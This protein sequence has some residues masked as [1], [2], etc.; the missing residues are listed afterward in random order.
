MNPTKESISLVG[1]GNVGYHLLEAFMQKGVPLS[2]VVSSGPAPSHYTGTVVRAVQELPESQL[3]ILC[4]PDD[5]IA[6]LVTEL[7]GRPLAYTSGSVRLDQLPEGNLGV[8]YPLQTFSKSR[9]VDLAQVPFF[10]EARNPEFGQQLF[11]LAKILSPS[12]DY[13]DSEKRRHMHIAAVWINNFT[14]HMVFQAQQYAREHHIQSEV[15]L[16]LL[17]ETMAKLENL[18]AYDAQTGPAR[19]GDLH[20]QQQHEEALNG[21]SKEM[22]HLI[23]QSI[24]ETYQK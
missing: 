11:D 20:V 18:S 7:P 14:N 6:N 12:V 16:P 15:F 4:V 9:P 10:I 23:S 3:T 5:R 19:R 13:A 22:Y 24:R 2:H 8:F 17:K 21:L 1:L